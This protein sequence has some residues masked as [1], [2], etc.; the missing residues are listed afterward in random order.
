MLFVMVLF[1]LLLV[2]LVVVVGVVFGC[3]AVG[4]WVWWRSD[5]GV[6]S[7]DDLLF[8]CFWWCWSR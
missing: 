7:G 6:G 8:F 4:A 5:G 1:Y 3:F 2:L